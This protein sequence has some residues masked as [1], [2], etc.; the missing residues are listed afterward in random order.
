MRMIYLGDSL[1][2]PKKREHRRNEHHSDNCL[3][4]THRP[5]TD[6]KQIFYVFYFTFDGAHLRD[7][8]QRCEHT[9]KHK[10]L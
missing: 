1:Q 9:I 5:L 8:G 10:R 6:N 7:F 3:R 4:N 2:T